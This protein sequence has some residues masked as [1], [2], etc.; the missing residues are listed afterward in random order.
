[1][2]E[3]WQGFARWLARLSGLALA[4]AAGA[5]VAE[6]LSVRVPSPV[7]LNYVEGFDH[8]D[9]LRVAAGAPLY[10]NPAEPPW[11][12]HVY[13]PLFTTLLAWLARLGA[14][15][16]AT[17]R[18]LSYGALLATA[19]LMI[20]AGWRRT[21][22]AAAGVAAVYLTLPL[23]SSW[24]ALLRPDNLAV[25]FAALGVV[26]AD[27]Q[28]R[29]NAVYWAIP[30]FLAAIACKQS[31][32][33]GLVAAAIFLVRFD[34]RRAVVFSGIAALAAGVIAGYLMWDSEGWFYFH[35]VSANQ[36]PYSIAKARSLVSLFLDDHAVVVWVGSALLMLTAIRRRWSIYAIWCVAS[37]LSLAALGK[38]G[39]DT[40]YFLEPV[41]ALGFL[42]ASE[43]PASPGVH[44]AV[45][46]RR[47]WAL[48]PL[49]AAALALSSVP[50][51]WR[52]SAW[53]EGAGARYEK[54]VLRLKAFRGPVVTDD[55]TLLYYLEEDLLFRPFAMTQLAYAGLW[56]GSP[57]VRMLERGEIGLVVVEA[58]PEGEP[59]AARYTPEMRKA[60]ADHYRR[61]GGYR[62]HSSF[63]ILAPTRAARERDPL[64]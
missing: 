38:S 6:T 9:V 36:N 49:L 26:I 1:M 61:V 54:M 56:N 34:L 52:Q 50:L 21:H 41:A 43:W 4:V 39:S 53:I 22:W 44:R 46:V 10:G 15:G 55:A 24:G 45:W 23:L 17:G 57:L 64:R 62:T 14:D 51:H 27:R 47:A 25:S 42:A 60:I 30:A 2:E 13:T 28:R 40:N 37:A 8:L 58:V 5:V 29:T 33:M 31:M 11:T 59:R 20:F 32:G 12:V 3:R 18:L 7:A 35:T 16:Y 19:A 63:E 48:V